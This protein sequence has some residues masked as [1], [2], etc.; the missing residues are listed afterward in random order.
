VRTQS[1]GDVTD[2]V[3]DPDD[4]I[5]VISTAGVPRGRAH[6]Y[7]N[8]NDLTNARVGRLNK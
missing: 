8:Y 4:V 6:E 2:D 7:V 1:I 5:A 3:T